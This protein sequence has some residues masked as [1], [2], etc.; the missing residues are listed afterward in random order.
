MS[1][2]RQDW[3]AAKELLLDEHKRYIDSGGRDGFLFDFRGAYLRFA[4]FED[5]D[6]WNA[7]LNG[8]NLGTAQAINANFVRANFAEANFASADF[9]TAKLKRAKI[10]REQLNARVLRS[11]E[12]G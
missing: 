8:V 10:L 12:N 2:S 4:R 9:S 6:M 7:Q 5:S 1:H 11:Q 3:E